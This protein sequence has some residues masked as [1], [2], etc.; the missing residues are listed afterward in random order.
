[1]IKNLSLKWKRF[2]IFLMCRGILLL[3][4]FSLNQGYIF[5]RKNSSPREEIIITGVLLETPF[6][7]DQHGLLV[8]DCRRFNWRPPDLINNDGLH[9][10]SGVSNKNLAVSNKNLGVFNQK[11]GVSNE[12][13]SVSNENLGVSH[14]NMES[15]MK[16]WMSPMK[17]WVSPTRCPYGGLQRD[18]HGGLQ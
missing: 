10:K 16:I 3:L 18:V 11:H 7:G 13:M 12:N 5:L 6:I 8:G 17:V 14:K 1:M 15:P 4:S 2:T 9:R